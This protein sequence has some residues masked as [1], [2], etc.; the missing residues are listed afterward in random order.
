ME[1]EGLTN[2]EEIRLVTQS[3]L[4]RIPKSLWERKRTDKDSGNNL[5][6]LV[7]PITAEMKLLGLHKWI[8]TQQRHGNT[9][10]AIN[11]TAAVCDAYAWK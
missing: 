11:F 8:R 7:K 10:A 4:Q 6:Q 1:S 2:L 9:L 3:G 5:P